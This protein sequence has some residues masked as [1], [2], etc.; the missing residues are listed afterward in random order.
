MDLVTKIKDAWA[1]PGT[2]K[3]IMLGAAGTLVAGMWVSMDSG[4]E[5]K[6]ERKYKTKESSVFGVTKSAESTAMTDSAAVIKELSSNMTEREK[7]LE[8]REAKFNKKMEE[9]ATT[10][11]Q[12]QATSFE[13]QQKVEELMKLQG[14][15]M[16]AKGEG[17]PGAAV[18]RVQGEQAPM[19]V[20]DPQGNVVQRRQTQIVTAQDPQIEGKLIRTIT[21]RNVREVRESGK[22]EEKMI[23]TTNL[24]Q[25]NQE[26]KSDKPAA[27][28]T[29]PNKSV[30]GGNDGEF[31]L[32]MGSII[33]GV[34]IN[35]VPA[36]TSSNGQ[37][38]PMPV[39]MRIKKEALMPNHFTLDVV[40][41]HLLGSAVGDLS[42]SRAF[43]RAEA[44]SCITEN[45]Q[46]IEKNLTAYAVSSSDGMAGIAGEVV[47]KSSTMMANAMKADFLAN[48]G[49]AI[50]PQR[51][52]SLNTQPGN[53]QLWQQQNAEYAASAGVAGGFGG[54]TERLAE[55]YMQMAEAA[56]PVIELLPGIEVDFIV[57]KGMT[58]KLQG[59]TKTNATAGVSNE[60]QLSAQA[61]PTNLGTG[62]HMNGK[63]R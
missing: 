33:T 56:H 61:I 26:V 42:S 14:R 1:E 43:I 5:K 28:K 58:M 30:N 44:I 27:K 57:Q 62:Q 47:F 20:M 29:E 39:L 53:T 21:Q 46:S 31:T 38:D 37:K 63:G 4:E 50:S 16:P 15:E 9:L 45:G 55:Y 19:N 49:K 51:V 24:S 41:C 22:V 34:L 60:Q 8:S 6:P 48:F 52:Q 2:R 32:T 35:G 11:L 18:A 10:V 13:T 25:R 54:A 12:A 7:E 23:A 17:V 59:D 36:P 3:L 40:D